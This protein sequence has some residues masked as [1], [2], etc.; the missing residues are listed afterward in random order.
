[1]LSPLITTQHFHAR[2]RHVCFELTVEPSRCSRA[3]PRRWRERRS[4]PS[5]CLSPDSE[6]TQVK[7][8]PSKPSAA[9]AQLRTVE[10]RLANA[11]VVST[12]YATRIDTD[13]TGCA[14]RTGPILETQTNLTRVAVRGDGTV[15]RT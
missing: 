2:S 4:P 5:G 13:I 10:S 6:T 3:P 15:P 7:C 9:L 8:P 12:A 11:V 1:M 14:S